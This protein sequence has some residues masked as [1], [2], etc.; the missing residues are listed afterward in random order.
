MAAVGREEPLRGLSADYASQVALKGKVEG[1]KAALCPGSLHVEF[2]GLTPASHTS[3]PGAEPQ[4][5]TK[6]CRKVRS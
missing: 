3:A 5:T 1:E 4:I 6:P 2:T